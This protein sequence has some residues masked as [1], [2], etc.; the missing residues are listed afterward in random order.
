MEEQQES[1]HASQGGVGLREVDE[2]SYEPERKAHEQVKADEVAPSAR[3]LDRGDGTERGEEAT[4]ADE[5]VL[6]GGAQRGDS[7]FCGDLLE[8]LLGE[9]VDNVDAG[10]GV[11][12]S[13]RAAN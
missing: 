13:D 12:E 2:E 7:S 9:P 4:D 5:V 8:D 3:E 10:H 1:A 11:K 6:L